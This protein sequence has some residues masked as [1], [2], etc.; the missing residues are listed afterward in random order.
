[1]QS[2]GID[3]SALNKY[4]KT[5]VEWYAYYLIKA[6]TKIITKH[7]VF[8]YTTIPLKT[9]FSLPLN[10]ENRILS[11][12][13]KHLWTLGRLS[14]ETATRPPDIFFTPSHILP[15][16]KS[17]HRVITI[18]DIGFKACPKF[19]TK[20]EVKSQNWSTSRAVKYATKIIAPSN[21][22]KQ[23]L[24]RYYNCDPR[25]ITVA[26]HGVN[27]DYKIITNKTAL[28]NIQ[29]KYN[30]KTKY[31]VSIG[32]LEKK[33]NILGILKALNILTLKQKS[34]LGFSIVFI[35]NPGFGYSEIEVM[36]SKYKL[37]KYIINLGF[38]PEDDM[39]YLLNQA[40]ALLFPSFYEGF[41]FPLLQ[42]MRCGVPIITSN[43]QPC[44]ELVKNAAILIDP[45]NPEE[46]ANAMV[47]ITSDDILRNK[48][49]QE[50]LQIAQNFSW[51]K[52]AQETYAALI[53]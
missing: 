42:A 39:P 2:I 20:L 36:I 24:I 3:A 1:M 47:Q 40:S 32:R 41:G 29:S 23:E 43:I 6:F 14:Y 19:Y 21:F 22:T 10:F 30:L 37:Q 12:K 28:Q 49:T 25:K 17:K 16:T 34:D 11:W 46:I 9:D 15:L 5:G 26:P 45:Y 4:F 52:C 18:H 8:L 31:I 13:F 51:E 48:I 35:G 33:K 44:K 38:M 7:K 27:P 50:G 53:S